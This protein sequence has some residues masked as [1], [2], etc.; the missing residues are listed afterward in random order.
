MKH[1]SNGGPRAGGRTPPTH[2]RRRRLFLAITVAR[3]GAPLRRL[4]R[5]E[6]DAARLTRLFAESRVRRAPVIRNPSAARLRAQLGD[7]LETSALG[8]EDNLVVYYSGHGCVA[9]GA[10]Y[11]C[12]AGFDPD[13]LATRAFRTEELVEMVVRRQPRPRASCGSSSTAVRPAPC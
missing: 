13:R 2:P 11:L 6:T 12:T 7:W 5:V 1:T 3:P 4:A 10:H 8:H 9:N